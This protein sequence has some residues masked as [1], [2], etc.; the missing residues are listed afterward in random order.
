VPWHTVQQ[1]E[2]IGSIA[3]QYRFSNWRKI[4]DHPENADLRRNRAD[5]HLLYPGDKVYVP[6]VDAGEY[7]CATDK[8]HTF[9]LETSKTKLIVIV[10]NEND[11]PIASKPYKLTLNRKLYNGTTDANGKLEH[12]IPQDPQEGV[13]EVEGYL[14]DVRV[15]HLDPIEQLK[16]V[17]QRLTNLGYDCSP[18]DG[19][20]NEQTA[21][22]IT[23]FQTEMNLPATGK[24]D[25]VTRNKLKTKYG[26]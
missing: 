21:G 16:G 10:K 13:L 8:L 25:D 3:K 15:G 23:R 24:L 26:C 20:L 9:C 6:P 4:Y 22:A 11:Q 1:G 7:L 5:P 2:W 14:Y 12:E 17:Q 18:I 19:I